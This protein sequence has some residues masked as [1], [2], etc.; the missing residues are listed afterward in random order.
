MIGDV[1]IS[2]PLFD[3]LKKKYPQA[4]IDVLLSPKNHF[5]LQNDPLIRKR[6]IYNKHFLQTISLIRG[7]RKEKYDFAVDLME[8]PICYVPSISVPSSGAKE[9]IWLEK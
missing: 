6:W 7:V 1:L 3:I 5:V 8:N 9:T 2:T 4:Q